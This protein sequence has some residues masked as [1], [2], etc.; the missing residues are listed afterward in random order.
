MLSKVIEIIDPEV[1]E[2]FILPD[3][4]AL[5]QGDGN[6]KVL[7]IEIIPAL[8]KCLKSNNSAEKLI[9]S[10]IAMCS[11]PSF[12]IRLMCVVKFEKFLACEDSLQIQKLQ[13]CFKEMLKDKN[14]KV[15]HKASLQLGPLI[16]NTIAPF[17]HPLLDMYLKLPRNTSNDKELQIHCAYYF[18]AILEKM[19]KESWDILNESYFYMAFS[20]DLACKK[21]IAASLHHIARMLE[22]KATTELFP[23]LISYLNDKA[24]K[25]SAMKNIPEIL[26][27]FEIDSRVLIMNAVKNISKDKNFRLRMEL[28]SKLGGIGVLL[29][30]Q[31]CF[32]D[33]WPICKIL[34]LDSIGSVRSLAFDGIGL[35]AVHI[36]TNAP[37]YSNDL[38]KDLRKFS[39][40]ANSLHRLVF[41]SACQYLIE[42]VEFEVAF[43][44]D[45]K[46]LVFDKVAAVRIVCA[47]VAKK[48]RQTSSR[49]FWIEIYDKLRIDEDR[50]VRM[51]INENE[52]KDLHFIEAGQSSSIIWPSIVRN[53]QKEQV[54]ADFWE[55]DS[56][57]KEF[58]FLDTKIRPSFLGFVE[59]AHYKELISI[60]SDHS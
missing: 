27:Y 56:N 35:S 37:E 10:F 48:A 43:G 31:V 59:D 18:P 49:L 12:E 32:K 23:I 6:S 57:D 30:S 46:K 33:L 45:F 7:A 15:R 25:T 51:Q 19:G 44:D 5:T 22:E 8:A 42:L 14:D 17:P 13:P 50:D 41:A 20:G 40:S 21:S 55:F 26:K 16:S 28:A 58:Y 2:I 34:C 47:R 9:D 4:L 1:C 24:L 54:Y 29:K 3:I 60:S 53:T 36:M 38:I 52:D 11:D 39:N